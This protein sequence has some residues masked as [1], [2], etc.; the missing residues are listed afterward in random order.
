MGGSQAE[1]LVYAGA[2]HTKPWVSLLVPNKAVGTVVHACNP[3]ALEVEARA[4]L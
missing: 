3:S 1:P 4:M 2:V